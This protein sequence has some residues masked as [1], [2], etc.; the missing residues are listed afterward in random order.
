MAKGI[1]S[2]DDA[3]KMIKRGDKKKDIATFYD[4]ILIQ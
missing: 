4:F 3:I 1:S 2:D